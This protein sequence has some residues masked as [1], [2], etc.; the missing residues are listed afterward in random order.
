MRDASIES[1]RGISKR[2]WHNKPFPKHTAWSAYSRERD[3]LLTHEDLVETIPQIESTEHGAPAH[4]IDDN[5]LPR[6]RRLRRYRG[7]V[8]LIKSVNDPPPTGGFLYAKGGTG[9]R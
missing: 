7:C 4:A 1:G 8:Q 9:V 5:I 6:Y 2:L 3:I